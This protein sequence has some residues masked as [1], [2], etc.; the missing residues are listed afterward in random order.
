MSTICLMTKNAISG[1]RYC[2]PEYTTEAE[3]ANRLAKT[4]AKVFGKD[5]IR[6]WQDNK[7]IFAE[8]SND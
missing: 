5:V 7:G 6:V 2:Y 3:Y 4:F 8:V 1:A